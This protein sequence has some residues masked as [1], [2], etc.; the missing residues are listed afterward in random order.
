[1]SS[2]YLY[3][4]Q[5]QLCYLDSRIESLCVSSWFCSLYFK[6]MCIQIFDILNN[7]WWERDSKK[8]SWRKKIFFKSFSS[9]YNS[10]L[11][12][13]LVNMMKIIEIIDSISIS[14]SFAYTF[15][16]HTHTHRRDGKWERPL[17]KI[18]YKWSR[19]LTTLILF[20]VEYFCLLFNSRPLTIHIIFASFRYSPFAHKIWTG[21]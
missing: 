21:K 3:F 6:W 11:Y 17:L 10:Q 20:L 18:G 5:F 8:P 13:V 15:A 7:G 12:L 4:F 19:N 14:T 9:S 1:M 2:S 16:M